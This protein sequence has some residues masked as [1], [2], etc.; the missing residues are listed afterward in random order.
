MR[1]RWLAG[2]GLRALVAPL[3][4][5]GVL[6]GLGQRSYRRYQKL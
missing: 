3:V 2:C 6:T 5:A 4:V 1:A